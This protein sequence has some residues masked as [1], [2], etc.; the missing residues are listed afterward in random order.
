MI[1]QVIS[2]WSATWSVHDSNLIMHKSHCISCSGQVAIMHWSRGW[3]GTDHVTNHA[4]ITSLSCNDLEIAHALIIWMITHWSRDRSC[5]EHVTDHALITWLSCTNHV[6]DLEQISWLIMQWS[7]RYH[8]LIS[9][10]RMHWS[11]GWSHTDHVTDHALNTWLIMHWS[12]DCTCTDHV[13]EH[14]LI[15]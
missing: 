9:R 8:A 12:R 2:A 10:L 4:V 13:T 3:S 5:T 6:A 1:S 14:A 15:T 7:R 11:Y